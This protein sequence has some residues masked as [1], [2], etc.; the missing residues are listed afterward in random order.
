M[1]KIVKANIKWKSTEEGGRR[2]L[3]PVGIK[4]YP[5]IIFETEELSDNLW[6]AELINTFIE[7]YKSIA[8]VT[9]LVDNAPFHNLKSGNSFHLYEGKRVVAEGIVQ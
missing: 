2:M 4:Y 7:G 5:L 8:D 9:Y 6:S 1:K 3:I